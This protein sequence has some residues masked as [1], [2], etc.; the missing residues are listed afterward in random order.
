AMWFAY[1]NSQQKLINFCKD[2]EIKNIIILS[3]DAHSSAIDDGKNAGFPEIMA[4]GLAQVNSHI[5]SIIYNNFKLNLWNQGGQGIQNK[6]FNH[7]YGKV[8][9]N[10]DSSVILEVI[11]DKDSTI[12]KHQIKTDYL[13]NTFKLKKQVRINKL[14]TFRKKIR[15]GFREILGKNKF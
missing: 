1:P 13:P 7:A 4:G 3:G 12:A 8:T 11:D 15:I 6:N 10:Q 5:A 2:N 14:F 9:V